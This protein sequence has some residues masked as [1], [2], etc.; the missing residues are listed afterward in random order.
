MLKAIKGM[1]L[2]ELWHLHPICLPGAALH[3]LR[4]FVRCSFPNLVHCQVM[5]HQ[6]PFAAGSLLCWLLE[7]QSRKNCIIRSCSKTQS[8]VGAHEPGPTR[9]MPQSFHTWVCFFLPLQQTVAYAKQTYI[10]ALS[11]TIL[12]DQTQTPRM[13]LYIVPLSQS[14]TDIVVTLKLSIVFLIM[15]NIICTLVTC[16]III[17]CGSPLFLGSFG[18]ISFGFVSCLQG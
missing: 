1:V 10:D 13:Y 4:Y 15:K 5:Y 17:F 2:W 7:L 18:I 14:F 6:F 11:L 12:Q 9:Q 3:I 16:L 8:A